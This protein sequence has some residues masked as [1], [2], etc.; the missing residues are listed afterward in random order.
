MTTIGIV[1]PG[2]MG[3]ALGRA[4][5]AGGARVVASVA[6]R[7]ERTRDLA[8]GLELLPSP[9]DVVREC[10]LLVSVVPP[11]A[12]GD[13]VEQVLRVAGDARPMLVDLNAVSP[14]TV[15]AAAARAAD[16]GLELVDG[17]ISGPPPR[18]GGD[19]LVYLSGDRAAEVAELPADGIRT[20]VV[21]ERIGTAS[22]VKMC[23]ASVYKG[24]TALWTQALQTAYAEGV[25]DV[26]LDDLGEAF[27]E[28]VPGVGRRIALS[29]S[30]AGRFVGEMEQISAAQD[31][32]GGSAE[33]FAGMAAVYAR[34][35]RTGLARLSPEEAAAVTDLE[36]V[37]RRLTGP[38]EA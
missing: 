23:T 8:R 7:S 34:L 2:A 4:W 12:A 37:L 3:S 26:V 29:T 25:L 10:D 20:R 27:P 35:S 1:S 30:K 32:A 22:A 11:A 21:G 14:T 15:R 28:Q 13:V 31:A 9:A 6:D 19:T 5:A 17:S 16:A 18:P 36:D 38:A 33:L 24:T